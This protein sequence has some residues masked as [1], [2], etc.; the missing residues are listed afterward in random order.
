MTVPH[1]FKENVRY[2]I[3]FC[4]IKSS[5]TLT[6]SL[7]ISVFKIVQ[8]QLIANTLKPMQK[9]S[10]IRPI[11]NNVTTLYSLHSYP[12]RIS[13]GHIVSKWFINLIKWTVQRTVSTHTRIRMI[14]IVTRLK[15]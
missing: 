1:S 10:G 6:I 15:L 5:L 2:F 8:I 9:Q 13:S 3:R 7:F 11:I 14:L 12:Q 4:D